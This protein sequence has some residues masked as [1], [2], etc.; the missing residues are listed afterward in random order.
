MSS[1]SSVF[2]ILCFF[3]VQGL[4]AQQSS[5]TKFEKILNATI[6]KV[7]PACVR[8]YG[9]DTV[10]KTQNSAQFSGVV[11]SSE[12]HILTVAHAVTPS[13]IYKVS[14]PDGRECLAMA[15][16]RIVTQQ[17]SRPDVAMMKILSAAPWPFVEMGW[18]NN[19]SLNHACF[20]ISYPESLAQLQPMVRFGAVI[21]TMNQWGF[22]ESSCIMETGDSG[23]PLFD[24]EGRVIGLH[25]RIEYSEG[26]NYEVPINLYRK[27]WTALSTATAYSTLPLVE[28]VIKTDKQKEK[29][30]II[31]KQPMQNGEWLGDWSTKGKAVLITSTIK[32][33]VQKICGTVFANDDLSSKKTGSGTIV[34]SK[35]SMV[36]VSPSVLLADGKNIKAEI[37]SRDAIN[38]LVL[39]SIATPLPSG[40]KMKMIDTSQMNVDDLGKLLFTV[41]PE[42]KVEQG[43][44]GSYFFTLPVRIIPGYFG[45]N[46]VFKEGKVTLSKIQPGSPVESSGLIVGDA[47]L[48]I[49]GIPLRKP[50]DYG[51]ELRKYNA[52]EKLNLQCIRGDSSFYKYIELTTRVQPI[53]NHSQ[54]QFEGGKSVR[55]DGFQ[56]VFTH[57]ARIRSYECGSPVFDVS[58]KLIGINIARYSHA[59]T[60]VIPSVVVYRLIA[61]NAKS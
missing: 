39:L 57:D 20:G 32:D 52:G 6:Q 27:Y 60:I 50:E 11:V 4:F 16:G 8:M 24:M 45:A 36:G 56:N 55:R 21:N 48:S 23:G 9:F 41:L 59:T 29:P 12:G 26:P 44:V 22:F 34:L 14:F 61:N 28:D 40:I 17:P 30:L 58:G 47:I 7:Y 51:N 46:A 2:L 1:K 18:S 13:K 31:P 15:L 43:V 38:D 35:S 19:L 42:G 10:S 54:D 25:S 5:Y 3:I 37:L 33:S 53:S 49:N